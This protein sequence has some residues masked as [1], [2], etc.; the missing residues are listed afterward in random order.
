[1]MQPLATSTRVTWYTPCRKGGIKRYCDLS[2]SLSHGTTS[3][4]YRHAGCLQLSRQR[5]RGTVYRRLD[6]PR[7]ELRSAGAY[8]LADAR[9]MT[10]D[11]CCTEIGTTLGCSHWLLC[12]GV[13]FHQRP[14]TCSVARYN[15]DAYT[16]LLR[17]QPLR[18]SFPWQPG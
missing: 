17:V 12:G 1:M 15:L 18:A 9:A 10:C 3:L 13:A 2:I 5:N 14:S 11:C 16:L 7:V 6:L 8:H 4:G